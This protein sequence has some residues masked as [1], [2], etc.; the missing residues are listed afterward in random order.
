MT[1][2]TSSKV[3]RIKPITT[4]EDWIMR[5]VLGLG[6]LWLLLGVVFPLYPILSKSFQDK[7]GNWIGLTNFVDYVTNPN[8]VASFFNSFYIAI[9][10]TIISVFLAFIFAYA[11]TRTAIPGKKIFSTVGMLPLYIPPIAHAIG[12]IYLFGRQGIITRAGWDINLYGAN[13]IIMGESLYCFPQALVI[14][15][16]ALSLTDA[17]LYEAA[18][19]LRTPNWR[20]FLTVTLPSVKYGLISAIFVCFT[21]AFTDFG[22]PKVVGGNFNVLATDIYKQVIGQQNF[23]MGATISVFLLIP[24]IIAFVVD[25]IIQRR[26]TALVS[27][28][29]VPLE[30]KP[31]KLLDSLMLVFCSLIILAAIIVFATIILASLIKI[32]P[33][34]FYKFQFSLSN[35]DFSRVAGGGYSAYRNSIVMSLLTAIFG[36]ILVFTGAYL[37]E[38]GKG[39]RW[40]RSVN[41]FLSTMPLALPGLVL[42]LGYLFFFVVDNN[43]GIN[44]GNLLLVLPNPF[45]EGNW[46]ISNPFGNKSIALIVVCNIIHFY[47]VCFLTANTALKQLDPEFEAVSASMSVPFYKTFWR[48]TLP[49]CLPTILGIGIYYF[50]NA[51]VTVSAIIFLRP[52]N[53]NLAA[54]SIINMDDA[55]DTASAAAMSTL[56]VVTSLGVRILYWFF[57]RGIE[58]RS[59]AWM[60]R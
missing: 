54:I 9:A 23:P 27:A 49:M 50:V 16:T 28:K 59:Q 55:G 52:D 21:L 60:K 32:W 38:K 46:I 25:R 29:A 7:N 56:L 12:L 44:N 51:M 30:P 8:L 6:T 35:Y 11:L 47:T 5:I 2:T 10:T 37:V 24:T 22:V 58:R 18:Q 43:L 42:G 14:L 33:Y 26:Q 57:T 48:V 13:G 3:N 20:T 1:T 45:A 39:L 41:Y 4:R 31:N 53:A 34:D 40:L 19:A 17:R 36:T 15:T